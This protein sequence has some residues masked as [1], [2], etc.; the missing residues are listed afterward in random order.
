MSTI[1]CYIS[2]EFDELT[3]LTKQSK[4]KFSTTISKIDLELTL[5][6]CDRIVNKYYWNWCLGICGL[7][8][9]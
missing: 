2:Q 7:V 9:I 4:S 5:I 1:F 8:T 6:G 3:F